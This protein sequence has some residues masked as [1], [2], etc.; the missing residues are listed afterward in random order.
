M[1]SGTNVNVSFKDDPR[2]GVMPTETQPSSGAPGSADKILNCDDRVAKRKDDNMSCWI[3]KVRSSDKSVP[4]LSHRQC[5]MS[6]ENLIDTHVSA[7]KTGASGQWPWMT[8]LQNLEA[9]L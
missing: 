9:S 1:T 8:D 6:M 5:I 7:S 3:E 2:S 4:L